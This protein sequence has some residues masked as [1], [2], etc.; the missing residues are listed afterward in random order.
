MRSYTDKVG[1]Y[2]VQIGL[3][4]TGKKDQKYMSKKFRHLIQKFTL[5]CTE[6]SD[7]QRSKIK[8]ISPI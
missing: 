1:S 7:C 4:T 6:T 3:H 8:K 2:T 5:A